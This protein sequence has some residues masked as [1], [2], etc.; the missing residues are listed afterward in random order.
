SSTVRLDISQSLDETLASLHQKG[1]HAIRRGERDGV[2]VEQVDST[3]GNCQIMYR[4]LADTAAGSFSI[5][6]YDYYRNFW[7]SFAKSGHG[8]LFFAHYDGQIVASAYALIFGN[9]STYKDGASIREKTVYGA[10]HYLQWEVIKW[11]KSNGSLVHDLCGTPPSDKI[12]DQ[13]HPHYGIGRFKTSFSKQVTDYIGVYDLPV[14][15]LAYK[16]WVKIGERLT[17]RLHRQ[18]HHEN[19]Y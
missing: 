2:R 12:G 8:Q 17:L 1:R 7:Q 6:S 3:D 16:I 10:S 13:S 15:K 9:K 14:N 11:A 19:W 5:R 18:L 4:L